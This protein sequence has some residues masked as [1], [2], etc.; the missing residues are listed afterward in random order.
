M[1]LTPPLRVPPTEHNQ[2]P[3]VMALPVSVGVSLP[4]LGDSPDPPLRC[5]RNQYLNDTDDIP[6]CIKI[7]DC[8]YYE[9][10]ATP[11]S[12]AVCAP[13]ARSG[14]IVEMIYTLTGVAYSTVIV[15]KIIIP[16]MK[17]KGV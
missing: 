4:T 9:K 5:P 1:S 17:V 14:L 15:F 10:R 8:Y 3:G 11:T 7:K 6:M 12:D 13:Y 2:N 16:I